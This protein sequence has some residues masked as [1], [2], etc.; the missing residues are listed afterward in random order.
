MKINSRQK[1]RRT[2]VLCKKKKTAV[3][4]TI[5]QNNPNR[6][7]EM[8]IAEVATTGRAK[9]KACSQTISKGDVR[10]G[11]SGGFLHPSCAAK[12]AKTEDDYPDLNSPSDIS[13]F[14]HLADSLKSQVHFNSQ[15]KKGPQ[16][17]KTQDSTSK[18]GTKRGK[19]EDVVTTKTSATAA[20]ATVAPPAKKQATGGEMKSSTSDFDDFVDYSPRKANLTYHRTPKAKSA[21]T[22]GSSSSPPL[23]SSSSQPKKSS[24]SAGVATGKKGKPESKTKTK[25]KAKATD[26][27]EDEE[28]EEEKVPPKQSKGKKGAAKTSS[29]NNSGITKAL[30]GS[31]GDSANAVGEVVLSHTAKLK[32][33]AKTSTST[34]S[35]KTGKR[36]RSA[37]DDDEDENAEEEEEDK[38][39]SK[40]K[41][42]KQGK[43]TGA[44]PVK[45]SSQLSIP[46]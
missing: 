19:T 16:T 8:W 31:K 10:L 15:G 9:C 29:A 7:Q 44:I 14:E 43:T 27:E 4:Q 30:P 11:I 17:Q 39:M 23:L 41:K 24:N 33:A 18:R 32:S 38:A 22:T 25:A 13:G 2:F 35:T 37:K 34:S 26:E 21:T 5:N 12:L 36:K 28:E 3:S 1:A 40:K 6:K 20:A 46:I 45:A 42:G